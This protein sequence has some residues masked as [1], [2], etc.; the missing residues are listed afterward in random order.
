MGYWEDLELVWWDTNV[1][2][3]S[4]CGQMIPKRRWVSEVDGQ[5]RSFCSLDC[6]ELYVSY[7]VPKHGH[8]VPA[9]L[10]STPP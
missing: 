8:T 9:P 7:W 6:E 2:N 1:V 4:F 3:C 10:L 5:V